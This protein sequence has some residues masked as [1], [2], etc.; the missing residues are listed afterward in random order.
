[1]DK[2]FLITHTRYD[3]FIE[4]FE[5]K[6]AMLDVIE[7]RSKDAVAISFKII[8][9]KELKLIKKEIV[10]KYDVEES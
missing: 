3:E 9:G 4:E 5:T 10:L 8:K 6:E 2:Y 1:M 7:K